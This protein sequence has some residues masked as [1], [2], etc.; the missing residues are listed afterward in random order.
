MQAAEEPMSRDVLL[1]LLS[2][3][4]KGWLGKGQLGAVWDAAVMR[5]SSETRQ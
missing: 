4:R 2:L 5:W 1:D 3:T